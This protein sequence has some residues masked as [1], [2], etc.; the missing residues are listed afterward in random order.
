MPSEV[1]TINQLVNAVR[2]K[3]LEVSLGP[4]TSPQTNGYFRVS[5]RDVIVADARLKGFE[6]RTSGEADADAALISA[7]GQPNPRAHIGWVS[8]PH[9]FK[10][11]QLIVLYVGCADRILQTLEQLMGAAIAEGPGCS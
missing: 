11:G 6:Y 5:S 10:R 8:A 2:A 1:G 7:D 9:F 3:G 4:E